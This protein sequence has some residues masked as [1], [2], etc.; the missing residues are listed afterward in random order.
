VLVV[1]LGR[2]ERPFEDEDDDEHEHDLPARECV[3]EFMIL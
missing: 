1:V 3:T 2:S